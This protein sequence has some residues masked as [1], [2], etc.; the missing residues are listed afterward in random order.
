MHVTGEPL[1]GHIDPFAA[2]A[3]RAHSTAGHQSILTEPV[4]SSERPAMV[5]T[6]GM[7]TNVGPAT[8][9]LHKST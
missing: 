7:G 1:D 3:M 2:R 6:S 8:P 9:R 5:D 4:A